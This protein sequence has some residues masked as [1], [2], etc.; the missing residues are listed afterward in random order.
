MRKGGSGKT[1]TTVNLA[2]AL[3]L[4]GKRTLLV[5]LDPQANAT[6]AVGINPLTLKHHVGKLLSDPSINPKAALY[7]ASYGLFILPSHVDLAKTESGMKATD[8]H[9]LK[10]LLEPL[11]EDYD[12][13]LVD[14]PPS[15]SV[16]TAG[17]LT[18][19]N[20]VIFP[21]QA[22]YF[23]ME[24][25][26]QAM[27]QVEK[28]KKGLNKDIKVIGILPTMVNPRTNISKS[29]IDTATAAYPD[30]VYP[31]SVDYS[32]RHPEATLAGVPIVVYDPTHNGAV[33][34]KK[35]AEAI[36]G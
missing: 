22:H 19:A 3:A 12:Y 7:K 36:D 31:F 21:L 32:V 14:T 33:M 24:G 6:V 8:V 13:V 27:D 30:L 11:L 29:V 10:G 23:A 2:A 15:E 25:L 35:L 16:L 1:T 17:A 20:E 34:Y 5:D 9:A 4:R 28:V 26:A 18:F